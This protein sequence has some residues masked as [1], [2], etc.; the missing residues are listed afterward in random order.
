MSS[1]WYSPMMDS[2]SALSQ[3]SPTLPTEGTQMSSAWYSPMMDSASALSQ[4]SPT[5][6]TEG[7]MPLCTRRSV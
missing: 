4:E 6:P 2:A 7:A 5:L 3:E 1:A